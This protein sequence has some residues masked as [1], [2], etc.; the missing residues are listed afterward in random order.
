[1]DAIDLSLEL[2]S[3]VDLYNKWIFQ[4]IEPYLGE[5]ILEIG[6]GIGNIS[7]YLIK[8]SNLTAID[9]SPKYIQ[10]VKEKFKNQPNFKAFL[11]DASSS[12][13][14]FLKKESF[15]SIVCLNVLEHIE[16]DLNALQN[17]NQLLKKG[18]YLNLLVPACSFAY[19]SLDREMKHFRRYQK[20]AL[21]EKLQMASFE[22]VKSFHMNVLGLAGW[23]FYGR[24]LKRKQLPKTEIHLIDR[25]VPVLARL[26]GLI[27]PP[28]GLS[29]I[30]IG[31]KVG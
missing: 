18:G 10:L 22:I 31:E 9:I 8:K 15:D 16:N 7:Q 5:N 23:L 30:V 13:P 25:L 24:I 14:D 20:R 6:C 17:M 28:I 4:N 19:G 2:M 26:E 11:W 27:P 3:E 1:M 12:I 29:I 21:E